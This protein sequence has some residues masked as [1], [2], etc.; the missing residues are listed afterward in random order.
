M[1]VCDGPMEKCCDSTT[2]FG[3]ASGDQLTRRSEGAR[4]VAAAQ[5]ALTEGGGHFTVDPMSQTHEHVITPPLCTGQ[6]V[7]LCHPWHLLLYTCPLVCPHINNRI[8]IHRR[9]RHNQTR[10]ESATET[11]MIIQWRCVILAMSSP[12]DHNNS[13]P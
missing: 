2:R 8:N 13:W 12:T 9:K 6:S 7:A 4:D 3:P 10:I 1:C 11:K 5:T